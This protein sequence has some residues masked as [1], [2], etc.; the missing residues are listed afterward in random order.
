MN[1][2]TLF[3]SLPFHLPSSLP[4]HSR[5]FTLL[6]LRPFLSFPLLSSP[7]LSSLHRLPFLFLSTV[8]LSFSSPPSSFP[9][10]L[11]RL[12][13]LSSP[14]SSFP[15]PLHRV[16]THPPTQ[17]PPQAGVTPATTV[18]PSLLLPMRSHVLPAFTV[19]NQGRGQ[20]LIV[21]CVWPVDTAQRP[22]YTPPSVPKV[23]SVLEA[24]AFLSHAYP[25]RTGIPLV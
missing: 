13:F 15:F 21:L 18:P 25:D 6:S 16:T 10:P 5:P 7:L 17:P 9:F 22:L 2:F 1:L 3:S 24:S 19:Q 4:F 12:P 8:F 14:P 20:Y 23:I 11:H